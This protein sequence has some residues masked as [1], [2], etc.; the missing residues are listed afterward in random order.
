MVKSIQNKTCHAPVL[1]FKTFF[2]TSDEKHQPI[3]S[4]APRLLDFIFFC[5]IMICS[6]RLNR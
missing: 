4:A 5:V 3:S 1:Q 2:F 6:G